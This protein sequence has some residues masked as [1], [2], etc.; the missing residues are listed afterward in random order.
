MTESGGSCS[1]PV[2]GPVPGSVPGSVPGPIPGPVPGPIDE[3]P[4]RCSCECGALAFTLPSR[5]VEIARCFCSICTSLHGVPFMAFAK[6]PVDVIDRV[7]GP[8]VYTYRS[9]NRA[10]RGYCNRCNAP[11]YMLYDHSPNVWIVITT[12]RFDVA[13][14]ET[15][16]LYRD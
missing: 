3:T 9:S 5:P 11:V 4:L 8:D 16:D 15:Y 10:V 13:G 12:L 7:R 14:V 6:Y 2:P 1:G